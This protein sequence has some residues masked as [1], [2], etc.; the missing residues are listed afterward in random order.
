MYRNTLIHAC[1]CSCIILYVV[2]KMPYIFLGLPEKWQLK[3][4]ILLTIPN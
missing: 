4:N 2:L 3:K 1:I